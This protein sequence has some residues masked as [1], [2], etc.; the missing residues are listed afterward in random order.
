MDFSDFSGTLFIDGRDHPFLPSHYTYL[1]GWWNSYIEHNPKHKNYI[2]IVRV[3][4]S[5]TLS[6][7]VF[8]PFDYIVEHN[9]NTVPPLSVVVIPQEPQEEQRNNE[10][11]G[12][13]EPVGEA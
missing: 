9:V 6:I 3:E 4:N 8:N 2:V 12:F 7:F 11:H 1:L 13:K 10:N 5:S